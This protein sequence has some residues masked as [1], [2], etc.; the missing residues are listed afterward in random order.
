MTEAFKIKEPQN[1]K[2]THYRILSVR[3]LGPKIWDL[4]PQNIRNC[5]LLAEFKSLIK[6]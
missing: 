1:I 6:L 3:Y 2:F 4:V 5:N